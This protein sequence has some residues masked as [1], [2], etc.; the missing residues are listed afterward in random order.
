MP[1]GP[2][3]TRRASLLDCVAL[4]GYF[5]GGRI[6]DEIF[7]SL[8]VAVV[9]HPIVLV[10]HCVFA[11]TRFMAV[12][13][14]LALAPILGHLVPRG[15]LACLGGKAPSSRPNKI[16]RA[17]ASSQC[18]RRPMSSTTI[19]L[20]QQASACL[21]KNSALLGDMPNSLR[22]FPAVIS[23]RARVKRLISLSGIVVIEAIE[24]TT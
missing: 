4:R 23:V 6:C 19:A 11:F 13:S 20:R 10:S 24:G 5:P 9:A 2:P 22:R 18:R 16:Q 7:R 3:T 15:I 17:A 14:T 12:V 8:F 21:R 1:G